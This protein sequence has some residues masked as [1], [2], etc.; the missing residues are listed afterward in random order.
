[1][2]DPDPDP[3]RGDER[4]PGPEEPDDP[5]AGLTLDDSFVAGASVREASGDERFE[6]LARI[7]AEHRRLAQQRL[8]DQAAATRSATKDRRRQRRRPSPDQPDS[9]TPSRRQLPAWV[10]V[11]VV[12]TLVGFMLWTRR[13]QTVVAVALGNDVRSL[14]V[15]E[16]GERPPASPEALDRP[17]AA[18]PPASGTDGSFAPV[19][20]GPDGEPVS[21]DPCRRIHVVMNEA[22]AP[23]EGLDVVLAAMAQANAAS[24][25]RFVFDGTTDE[26]FA[27]DRAPYQPDWYPDVWAPVLVSWSDPTAVPDLAGDIAGLGGSQPVIDDDAWVFVTGTVTLDAATFDQILTNSGQGAE[28]ATAIVAHEFGHVLG[29]NHVD[30]EG[31]L[32]FASN[33]GQTVFGPGDLTGFRALHDGPCRPDL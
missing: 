3:C 31:E 13:D 9:A 33:T 17:V 1:M 25:F 16:G 11:A 2:P 24:G 23:P 12:I 14:G 7:D 4:G 6:R 18:P 29:L 22:G 20:M 19:A 15:V 32:M 8:D 26:V 10:S 5:F 30:D 27:E 21:Y 28:D